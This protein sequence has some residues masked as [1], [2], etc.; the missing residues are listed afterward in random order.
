MRLAPR[1]LLVGAAACAL[2]V[3]LDG[4]AVAKDGAFFRPPKVGWVIYSAAWLGASIWAQP[5]SDFAHD[6][7]SY[8]PA[9]YTGLY[10]GA[11]AG[12]RIGDAA[13][14]GNWGPAFAGMLAGGL[15]GAGAGVAL[16]YAASRNGAVYYGTQAA[17]VSVVMFTI[18]LF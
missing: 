13:A 2:L 14:P 8:V 11:Q 12:G 15:L 16:G 3:G 9:T 17:Y 6:L 18:P 10:L 4:R 7:F 5:R 1:S